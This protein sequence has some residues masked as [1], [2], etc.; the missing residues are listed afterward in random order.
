MSGSLATQLHV[1]I[2][3]VYKQKNIIQTLVVLLWTDPVLKT[4]LWEDFPA[5]LIVGEAAHLLALERLLHHC[6]RPV[7]L[8]VSLW[9]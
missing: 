1:V 3:L 7:Q 9:Y 6:T 8:V 4:P 2:H 5:S